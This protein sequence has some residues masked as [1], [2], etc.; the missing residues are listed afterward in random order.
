VH[1][2]R[3]DQNGKQIAEILDYATPGHWDP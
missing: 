1:Q 2:L 3:L